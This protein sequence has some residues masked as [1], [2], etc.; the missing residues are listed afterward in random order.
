MRSVAC[1]V[2]PTNTE[3]HGP[4]AGSQLLTLPRKAVRQKYEWPIS[5]QW[6]W[7]VTTKLAR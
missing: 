5:E 7:K 2:S 3:I 1:Y 4:I 6:G